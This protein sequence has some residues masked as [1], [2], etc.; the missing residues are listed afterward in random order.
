MDI[1]PIYDAMGSNI[2]TLP[3][4]QRA[5]YTT[6][7]GGVPW[8]AADWLANPG[9]VRIDQ[10]PTP[11]AWDAL[12]DV[13]DYERGAVTLAELP[14]RAKL[15]LAAY[16]GAHRPGQRSP[17]IYVGARPNCTPVVNTLL[18]AGIKGGIALAIAAPG[19]SDADARAIIEQEAGTPWPIVWVQNA[20]HMTFDA[21]WASKPW[22]DA[23]SAAPRVLARVTLDF[24]SG[25]AVTYTA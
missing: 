3:P 17:N 11:G 8:S 13:Q 12:A 20:D 15:S 22:L 14:G 1:V 10:S 18:A 19:M 9:A 21:G 24:S 16:H 5:G 7:S 2:G 4:G 6:G 25:P 23:V